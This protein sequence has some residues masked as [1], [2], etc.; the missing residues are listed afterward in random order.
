MFSDRVTIS[1]TN[2]TL[3]F[4][5]FVAEDQGIY[6]CLAENDNGTIFSDSIT[7]Q[8]ACKFSINNLIF[9]F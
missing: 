1:P 2:G 8:Q 4:L 3:R 6:Q 5:N 7:I 9:T